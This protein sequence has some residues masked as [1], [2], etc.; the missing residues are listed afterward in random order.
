[1]T[2]RANDSSLVYVELYEIPVYLPSG[3]QLELYIIGLGHCHAISEHSRAVPRLPER[4]NLIDCDRCGPDAGNKLISIDKF[5]A[6]E[7]A[8]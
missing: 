8:D 3:K 6:K 5:M 7:L 4:L 2:Q 1:M